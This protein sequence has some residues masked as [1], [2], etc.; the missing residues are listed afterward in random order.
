LPLL[1][2]NA[3][4]KGKRAE[5]KFGRPEGLGQIYEGAEGKKKKLNNQER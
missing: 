1:H 2:T 5:A 4:P 3:I